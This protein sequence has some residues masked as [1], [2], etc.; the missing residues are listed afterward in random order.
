MPRRLRRARASRTGCGRAAG[1]ADHELLVGQ[2]PDLALELGRVGADAGGRLLELTVSSLMP[3]FS[4][5]RRTWTSG[6]SIC[7]SRCDEP[8]LVDLL[9]LALGERVD[10]HGQRGLVVLGVDRQP[11]LLG[12]LVE[13]VA[14][15]GGIEQVGGDLGVEDEVRRDVA[16][17]LGVV[18]DD[19]ALL[20]GG[21]ELGGVVDLARERVRPRRRRRSASA[22][23]AGSARPRRSRARARRAQRV[24]A[25]HVDVGG[26]AAADRDRLGVLLLGARIASMSA[27]SSASSRRRSGSRSPTRGRSRAGRPVGAAVTSASR[28]RSIGTS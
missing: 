8:A 21:D 13:R 1:R 16:E 27:S 20:G 9:G 3:C 10:G 19:G 26:L 15:A 18:R 2:L 17:R 6:S 7:S 11:A 4:H 12:E 23:R 24:A 22:P 28:S 25:E 14:A 5:S